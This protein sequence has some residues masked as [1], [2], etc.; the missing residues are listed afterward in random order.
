MGGGPVSARLT[1]ALLTD[2]S[3]RRHVETLKVKLARAMSETARRLRETSLRLWTEPR[4]GLFLW[5]A[6]PEG[7]DA[8]EVARR[9]MAEGVVLAPGNVF[10]VGQTAGRYLRF[11]VA[12]STHPRVFEVLGRAIASQRRAT[13]QLIGTS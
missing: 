13:P 9:A 6:L 1:H 11:N 5:A 3:Y 7:L 2:G 10:S 12:Q 8:A 4:G